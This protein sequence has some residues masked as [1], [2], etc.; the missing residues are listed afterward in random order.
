MDRKKLT[1]LTI[2]VIA[3]G[4]IILPTVVVFIEEELERKVLEIPAELMVP[5]GID[6]TYLKVMEELWVGGAHLNFSC[7][8]CHHSP[9]ADYDFHVECMDC[10]GDTGNISGHWETTECRDCN[11][12]HWSGGSDIA[13][14]FDFI[15]AG[16]FGL[17]TTQFDVGEMAG[18][19]GLIAVAMNNTTMAGANEACL[20]CHTDVDLGNVS[21]DMSTL[22][23]NKTYMGFDAGLGN[24]SNF[25]EEGEEDT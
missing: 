25:T 6:P 16:G 19:K 1:C 4:V 10:H 12:C 18:H 15:S 8:T 3:L 7:A 11:I 14:Y 21:I 9:I 13:S 20:A 22:L 23:E 24:V 5:E 2:L 17:N